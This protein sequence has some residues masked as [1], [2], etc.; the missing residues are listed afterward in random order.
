[1]TIT[2]DTITLP[3]D[4][5]WANEYNWSPVVQSAKKSVTGAIIIQEAIQQKGRSIVLTGASNAAW[6]DRTT[7]DALQVKSNTVDLAMVLAHNGTAY[8]VIFD[9]SSN[10]DTGMSV[11][12]I[13]PVANPTSDHIYQI[14]LKFRKISHA[15]LVQTKNSESI[16][17]FNL[18]FTP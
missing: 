9:R 17:F 14:T 4:L 3:E 15:V 13:Y 11:K 6:I 10:S 16:I 2:L 18:L 7:L 1:M 12:E 8:N 5:V